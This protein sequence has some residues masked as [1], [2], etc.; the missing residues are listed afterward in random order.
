MIGTSRPSLGLYNK[1]EAALKPI[2][3]HESEKRVVEP[4]MSLIDSNCSK[5]H[6]QH[7]SKPAW[8]VMVNF[9][10][11]G[12]YSLVLRITLRWLGKYWSV[13]C[14]SSQVKTSKCLRYGFENQKWNKG[15][16]AFLSEQLQTE[17]QGVTSYT[18]HHNMTYPK[19]VITIFNVND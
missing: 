18:K 4:K 19:W 17:T 7:L 5:T 16:K 6:W 11:Y 3:K 13:H 12:F 2:N 15:Y 8:F 1:R 10:V 9:H 14:T